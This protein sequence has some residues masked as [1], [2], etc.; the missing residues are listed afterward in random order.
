M[1]IAFPGPVWITCCI[2]RMKKRLANYRR[3]I[4]MV[5]VETA[6]LTASACSSGITASATSPTKATTVKRR[7]QYD[8][9][10]QFSG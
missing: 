3:Q 1:G 4:I 7:R 10:R 9:S 5:G 8:G 6:L 2:Q